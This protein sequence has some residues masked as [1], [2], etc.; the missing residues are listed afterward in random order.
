MT[1]PDLLITGITGFIG[2]KV[3]LGALDGGYSV[4][5]AAHS[6]EKGKFLL[7]HPKIQA[8]DVV[9]D[10]FSVVEVPDI[11]REGA[12]D[13][14]VQGVRYI[15]HSALPLPLLLLDPQTGIYEPNIRSV[16]T[17]LQPALQAPSLKCLVITSSVV[18]N[19]TYLPGSTQEE[20]TAESRVPDT[21]GPFDFMGSAYGAGKVASLNSIN[22]SIRDERPPIA[23][24]KILP[25]LV[26]GRDE[27][28]LGVEDLWAVTNHFLLDLIITGKSAPWPMPLGVA[29]VSDVAKVHLMALK[30]AGGGGEG[31]SFPEDVGVTTANFFNDAWDVVQK[32][33][34][35]AVTDGVFR[36]GDQPTVAFNWNARQ[37]EVDL[38]F[39][40]R[41]YEDIVL[42]VAGQYLE[43]TGKEKAQL[44][45]TGCR[46]VLN[47]VPRFRRCQD[48]PSYRGL[49]KGL[50]PNT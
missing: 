47:C 25:S 17:M 18:G 44:G 37:M 20:I 29:D 13:D 39:S 3:L 36:R 34:P 46:S 26:L 9:P 1:S 6:Q 16:R 21:P 7:S 49:V 12:Y 31:A 23:V 4:R 14:A 24:V 10:R 28:A 45:S 30:E 50:P 35:K 43:L 11:C 19:T 48:W 27:R 22:R 33:F 8:L 5:A 41:A 38:S 15:I 40:F 32:H 2:F 42:D